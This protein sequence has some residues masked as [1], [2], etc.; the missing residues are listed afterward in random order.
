MTAVID[1][2]D[3]EVIGY[4]FAVARTGAGSGTSHRSGLS[5]LIRHTSSRGATPS[6]AVTTG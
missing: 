6:F 4:E 1:C 5:H 3:R 2:H